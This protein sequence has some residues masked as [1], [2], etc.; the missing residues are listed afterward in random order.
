ML[1]SQ[2]HDVRGNLICET[3]QLGDLGD[4]AG[5]FDALKSVGS[6]VEGAAKKAG[7]VVAQGAEAAGGAVA[8]AG[9]AAAHAVADGAKY[10]CK[11]ASN[12]SVQQGASLAATYGKYIPPNPVVPGAVVQGVGYGVQAAGAVCALAYPKKPAPAA[13]AAPPTAVAV[14]TRRGGTQAATPAPKSAVLAPRMAAPRAVPA[15]TS[16]PRGS[17]AWYAA[18]TGNFRVAL[19]ITSA[20]FGDALNAAPTTCQVTVGG[21]L[22]TGT[23]VVAPGGGRFCVVTVGAA[24]VG[25]P[26][27]TEDEA[28]KLTGG[29]PWY[30]TY[31]LWIVGGTSLLGLGAVSFLL[32]RRRKTPPTR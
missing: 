20:G 25:I 19:P 27:I 26:L 1:I 13:P 3:P 29:R 6:A 23:L 5:V 15:T 17:F 30:K 14:P 8:T 31:K 4:L 12:P 7:G 11:A 28:N 10:A 24:P 32:I 9:K 18:R 22:T 2:L 16:Y 21:K